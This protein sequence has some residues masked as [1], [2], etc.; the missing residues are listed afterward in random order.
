MSAKHD[1]GLRARPRHPPASNARSPTRSRARSGSTTSADVARFPALARGRER[2][3]R[4]RRRRLHRAVD[5]AARQASATPARASCCSRRSAS[6]GRRRAATAG[7]ARRASPTARRTAS[8]A[9]PT[10]YDDADAARA[11]RTSTRSSR[12]SREYGMDCDFERTGSS[13][14]RS[15]RTRWSGW[16]SPMPRT[17][18][19]SSSTATPCGPRSTRPPTSPVVGTGAAPPW[20]TR[21]SSPPSS[22]GSRRARGRDPRGHCR[23]VASTTPT[24]APASRS[25]PIAAPC[26]APRVALATNV[27]PS[28][29]KR[30]RL[31]TVPVYD[32]VLMTEP[33]T[34]EQLGAIGWR[35]RQG[36]ER[37][38]EPVPL[39]PAERRQ[40][41]PVRR[42]RRDLPLRPQGPDRVRGPPLDVRASSRATSP[43]RSRSSRACGFTHRWAGRDRHL[44]PVLRVLRHARRGRVAYAAGFTG[45][46]VGATRFAADVMLDLLGGARD[47]AHLAR[48]GARKPM[49]F[50][51]EPV[52]SIGI[53]LTRWS[54][55]RADH[56]QGRRNLLLRTLDA[57]GLGF[58][59]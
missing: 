4:G 19:T 33:L 54:L 59:S 13:R 29:L 48:D 32:Y 6:A 5:G 55:D 17:G 38:R 36:V 57:L 50:P 1:D 42:L 9:G 7:S 22:R 24:A 30:N 49:P 47:R 39:L 56:R 27:F 53:Q 44:H 3:P 14:S 41:D 52:A 8:A 45:L 43:R 2:G 51:P 25:S 35:N 11:S 16:P 34:A 18:A 58:D 10:R 15:S 31:M 21:R 26:A 20:C 37:P 12:P 23:C 28:L 40:P 46:G